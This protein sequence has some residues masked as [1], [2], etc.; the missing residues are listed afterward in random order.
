MRNATQAGVGGLLRGR[1]GLDM[2]DTTTNSMVLKRNGKL[3]VCL[4]IFVLLLLRL[5]L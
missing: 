4:C 3:S 5:L 1:S 2:R